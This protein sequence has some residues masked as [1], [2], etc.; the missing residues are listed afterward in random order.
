MSR[1]FVNKKIVAFE[2]VIC[3]VMWAKV[4]TIS[5]VDYWHVMIC[6]D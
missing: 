3:F 2:H 1:V 5:T 4:Y 6:T